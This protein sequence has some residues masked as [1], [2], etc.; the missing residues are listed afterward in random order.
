MKCKYAVILYLFSQSMLCHVFGQDNKIIIK[1]WGIEQQI[2]GG[3]PPADFQKT[4]LRHQ[5][6]FFLET[7]AH[8]SIKIIAVWMGKTAF[9][10]AEEQRNNN[11]PDRDYQPADFDTKNFDFMQLLITDSI[12]SN[13][14]KIP[15]KLLMYN[16]AVI[17]YSLKG[18]K[19]Y[20]YPIKLLTQER[21]NLP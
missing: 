6:R 5:Y 8:A 17:V 20:F 10:V 12:H 13:V 16:Q 11:F 2:M 14:L 18:K 7:I 19:L 21:L 1:G 3:A 9:A 4:I 15:C